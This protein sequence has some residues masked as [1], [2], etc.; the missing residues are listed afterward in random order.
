M[1]MYE[2]VCMYVYI[3]MCIY[4][5][6]NMYVYIC[7]CIYVCVYMY[8]YACMC[9]YVCVYMYVYICMC[10]YVCVYMYA[11]LIDRPS[12]SIVFM[13][14][15]ICIYICKLRRHKLDT[16]KTHTN[17]KRQYTLIVYTFYRPLNH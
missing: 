11:M 5:C 9:I 7:S 1:C 3:C 14:K 8:V 16:R 10:I 6:V 2:C 15:Y 17:K 13:Q 12:L 4:V